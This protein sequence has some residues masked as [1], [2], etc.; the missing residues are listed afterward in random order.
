MISA[1]KTPVLRYNIAPF[2]VRKHRDNDQK[3]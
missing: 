1:Q 2:F 3:T